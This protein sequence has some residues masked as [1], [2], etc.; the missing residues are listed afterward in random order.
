MKIAVIPNA[1]KG[2]LT[3][4]QAAGCIERGLKKAL[5]GVFIVRI[6]MADGGDGTLQAIIG[7]THGRIVTCR[8]CDPLGRKIVSA[9]GLTGNGRTAVVEMALASGL[10]LLKP[11]ERNPLRASSHGTGELI[12]AALD[13]QVSEI[14]IGIGGSA[15][16]DGGLGMAE[17]LGVR[18]FD[19]KNSQ[20]AGNGRALS[21]L[22]RIDMTGIDPR[23]KRTKIVVACDV[24]NPLYGPH[25]AACIYGPQKGA[26]SA[27][28]QQLDYGLR[29]LA[30]TIGRDF[31]VKVAKLPGAGAAGGLGAGLVAFLGAQLRPGVEIVTQ[32][33][34]L[35]RKLAGCDLVITGEGRL[36]GQTVSGKAPAEVAMIARKLGIPTIAIC[37][38]LGPNAGKA[39][40]FGIEASFSALEE[41]LA[42]DEL[43]RRAPGML[44]RCAEQVGRL[45]AIR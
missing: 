11:K 41:P 24:V 6:P 33:V 3:A 13:R 44:Q 14:I 27:M 26:T 35:A 31:G 22:S 17:A 1:F 42:E 20:L 18:F 43:R 9:F 7:A 30:A 5:S 29:C 12:R 19:G 21:K 38:S 8:V 23:L 32:A 25:G 2:T 16:N 40:A 39:R 34:G 36:D 37:G 45:L 15:T 4:S 28:V 10:A